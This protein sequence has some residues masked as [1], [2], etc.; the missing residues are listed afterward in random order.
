MVRSKAPM[1]ML[2]AACSSGFESLRKHLACLQ[3]AAGKVL[4]SEANPVHSAAAAAAGFAKQVVFIALV[5]APAADW[6]PASPHH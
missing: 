3:R 6:L 5:V 1:T 4:L 2:A